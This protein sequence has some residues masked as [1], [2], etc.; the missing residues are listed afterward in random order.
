MA[1][2][3]FKSIQPDLSLQLFAQ[4]DIVSKTVQLFVHRSSGGPLGNQIALPLTF[5]PM[6]EGQKIDPTLGLSFEEAQSLMDE[7]YRAGMR[8]SEEG[9]PGEINA[10]RNHLK[11]L[12][13]IVGALLELKK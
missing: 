13:D 12:K 9:S 5:S 8:P 1:K 3:S 11:D 6:V 7:L 10:L 4:R 2:P